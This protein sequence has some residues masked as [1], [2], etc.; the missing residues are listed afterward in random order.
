MS[1][2]RSAVVAACLILSTTTTAPTS[3]HRADALGRH[4]GD[5]FIG[6][7][8]IRLSDTQEPNATGRIIALYP[9]VVDAQALAIPGGDSMEDLHLTLVDFGNDVNGRTD[10]ELQRRLED[11]AAANTH[12]IEAQVF[13]HAVLNPNNGAFHTAVVYV[14]GDSPELAP[15]R[16]HVL[17]FSEQLFQLPTQ[18]EPWLAHITAT[19]GPSDTVLTYTGRVI[20]DRIGLIWGDRTTYFQLG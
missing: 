10:I 18:H 7:R 1:V 13:G 20:F 11:F 3:M 6:T 4:V 19:Y 14:V 2:W 15:L 16:D 9:R 12:P 5:L 8:S 17:G